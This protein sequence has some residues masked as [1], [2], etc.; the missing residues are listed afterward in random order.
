MKKSKK[1]S[2]GKKRYQ[3]GNEQARL[4]PEQFKP[5]EGVDRPSRVRET[6][7]REPATLSQPRARREP[8]QDEA[9]R[10]RKLWDRKQ[11]ELEAR[12]L[13]AQ[14]RLTKE[15]AA[16]KRT[17]RIVSIA[18]TVMAALVWGLAWNFA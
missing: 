18:G 16:R 10:K 7:P 14:A 3:K 15:N 2:A 17:T 12:R 9:E 5:R 13:D 11:T 4:K 6:K 1:S 8:Q